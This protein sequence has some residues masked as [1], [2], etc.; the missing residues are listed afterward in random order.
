MK[1]VT[2]ISFLMFS[3]LFIIGIHTQPA[4]VG[5]ETAE[6]GWNQ[7]KM[8]DLT[9]HDYP[10]D[11]FGDCNGDGWCSFGDLVA[12]IECWR[13]TGPMVC[14]PA[15]DMDNDE[16]ITLFDIVI[17]LR[18]LAEHP[19]AVPPPNECDW[20][21]PEIQTGG[22]ITLD[23]CVGGP[24]ETIYV[25]VYVQTSSM[26]SFHFSLAYDNE[27]IEEIFASDM[28][29]A[30]T[31]SYW[32]RRGVLRENLPPENN[33]TLNTIT[34]SL[35]CVNDE[36]QIF[37]PLEFPEMT[38]AFDIGVVISPSSSGGFHPLPLEADPVYGPPMNFSDDGWES[39]EF[40]YSGPSCIYLPGDCD[41]NGIPLE[42]GDVVAMIGMYRGSVDPCYL[43]DC[44]ADPPGARFAATADPNG[45]CVA[46]ELGDVVTEIGAYRG[47][48]T[49]SGCVDCPGSL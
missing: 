40:E 14:M 47:S 5:S 41:H 34:F 4:N 20:E 19:D 18:W 28:N 1:S 23:Y 30:F 33:D 8:P 12:L 42:L 37:G 24:G 38:W 21:V 36:G 2:V 11:R 39:R 25:G 10:Y 32:T 26:S 48:N 13:E 35:A 16:Q 27:D 6:T 22:N 49:A 7:T 45:N 15:G 43:C 46:F 3:F 31:A 44:D 9:Y 29:P 17:L